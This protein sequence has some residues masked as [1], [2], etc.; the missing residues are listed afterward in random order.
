MNQNVIE[1]FIKCTIVDILINFDDRATL[2]RSDIGGEYWTLQT[3]PCSTR[4]SGMPMVPV[5]IHCRVV[6]IYLD[7]GASV[8]DAWVG[9]HADAC[10]LTGRYIFAGW[11]AEKEKGRRYN[12]M[13]RKGEGEEEGRREVTSMPI[14]AIHIFWNTRLLRGTFHLT[15]YP[16]FL[17]NSLSLCY[18]D[19]VEIPNNV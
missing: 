12:R 2:A 17:P 14:R 5:L 9:T 8:S 4:P 11:T 13:R 7:A 3:G 16:P 18:F 6:R 15:R 10:N 1:S 19:R